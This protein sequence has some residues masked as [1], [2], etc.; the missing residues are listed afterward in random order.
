M[1]FLKKWCILVP[2]FLFIFDS[3]FICVF[4]KRCFF[5]R[6]ML[7]NGLKIPCYTFDTQR[8]QKLKKTASLMFIIMSG[9]LSIF[10]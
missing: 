9:I 10:K 8:A 7:I 5:Y 4:D 2:H 3:L 6:L 1:R